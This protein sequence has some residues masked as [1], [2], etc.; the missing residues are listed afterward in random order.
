VGSI[1]GEEH[2]EERKRE[3]KKSANEKPLKMQN[4]KLTKFSD[5]SSYHISE[6][7]GYT[8]SRGTFHPPRTAHNTPHYRRR[9]KKR[10][11]KEYQPRSFPPRKNEQK[12][13]NTPL[14]HQRMHQ[15]H[16][17]H[18]LHFGIEYRKPITPFLLQLRRNT[19]DIQIV[20]SRRPIFARRLM[21]EL[22][23]G[24]NLR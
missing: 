16:I 10:D 8:P 22:N 2:E 21:T 7:Y 11:E 20:H 5:P 6:P 19:A 12:K 3:K 24:I 23:G 14:M 1:T 18:P 15:T 9:R 17:Q 13:R 4:P